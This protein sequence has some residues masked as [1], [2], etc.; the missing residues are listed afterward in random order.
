MSYAN[1]IAQLSRQETYIVRLNL[2]TM[3]SGGSYEELASGEIP[4]TEGFFPC[5]SDISWIPSRAVP[6]GGLGYLGEISIR[7]KDFPY[8]AAGTYFGRLLANNIYYLNRVVD[9]YVGFYQK[10]DTF[11]LS[12]F[13]KRTYF[14]KRIDGPDQNGNVTIQAADV[15]SRL[16]E[17]EAPKQTDAEV[18][19]VID[20]PGPGFK[21]IYLD[22]TEGFETNF[23]EYAIINDELVAY[24]AM[25]SNSYIEVADTGRAQGGTTEE[26]ISAGDTVRYVKR[27]TGNP[28]DAIR[29][30]IEDYTDIDHATYLPDADW[31]TERDTYFLSQTIDLW[32]VETTSVDELINNICKQYYINV[33]WDDAAQEIKLKA[34]GPV[35][36][37]TA[38][39]NDDENI[40]DAQIRLVRD[41]RKVLSAVW[42]FFEK[43]DKTGSN[44]AKNF[45]TVYIKV[46]SGIESSLGEEKVLKIYSDT[47]PETS[48]GTASKVTSR[49]LAR[50]RE[51]IELVIHVDAKD[52]AVNIGDEITI[53]SSVIQDTDGTNLQTIM[54]VIEKSQVKNNRYRYKLVKTGQNVGDRYGLIA[55]AG[56]SDYSAASAAT[57]ET[58]AFIGNASNEMSNG[59]DGYLIS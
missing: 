59:D 43:I 20:F 40:L 50:L 26:T 57:R 10:G 29:T 33:W 12:N 58:Y 37:P 39:W 27:I 48:T 5:V 1:G 18:T 53:D 41:Q 52:S 47:V 4:P 14:L 21:E 6:D 28:V 7:C 35:R 23:T 38:T 46:D 34:L 13:Q 36:T 55:P 44:D 49:I 42:Y 30:L 11:N 8:G 3:I 56:T 19:Q 45:K 54:R 32:I 9:V 25:V 15:L 16:K 22:T 51:P 2:D 17:S 31:N 24:G